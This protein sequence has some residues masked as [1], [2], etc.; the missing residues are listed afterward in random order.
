MTSFLIQSRIWWSYVDARSAPA[1]GGGCRGVAGRAL[2]RRRARRGAAAARLGL[3]PK[4]NKGRTSAGRALH[5][6]Q[7]Q[8]RTE[9]VECLRREGAQQGRHVA[10]AQPVI[11]VHLR[12]G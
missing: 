3:G 2:R 1:T 7:P 6:Q 11:L 10:L 9:K 4:P 5:R 8:Q 12:K